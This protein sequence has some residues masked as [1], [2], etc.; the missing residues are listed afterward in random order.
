MRFS[1]VF[2]RLGCSLV[3]WMVIFAYFLWLAVAG[4]LGCEADGDSLFLLLT[5]FGPVA[6]VVALL[7]RA[8]RTL[9]DIH[10]ILRWLVVF[11]VLLTPF[12][13]A[14]ITSVANTVLLE[15]RA[16]CGS[17]Q[18][19]FWQLAWVPLQAAAVLACLYI[20]WRLWRS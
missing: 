12:A 14:S 6:A 1:E 20:F 3:A 10:K 16:I 11:P 18:P 17:D 15:G 7:V 8:T 4:R 2:L 5:G 19:E 9:P 13:I